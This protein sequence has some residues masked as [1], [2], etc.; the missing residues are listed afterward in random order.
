MGG[1]DGIGGE[2]T[3]TPGGGL[4]DDDWTSVGD[5]GIHR[6][7]DTASMGGT[8][9]TRSPRIELDSFVIELVR[10]FPGSIITPDMDGRMPLTDAIYDWIDYSTKEHDVLPTAPAAGGGG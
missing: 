9:T 2:I 4:N 1:S 6:G 3:T 8:G 7:G 10:A 5:G